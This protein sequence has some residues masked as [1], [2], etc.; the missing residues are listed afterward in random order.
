MPGTSRRAFWATTRS[1]WTT[2][3]TRSR[4]AGRRATCS[5]SAEG[6]PSTP[7][8][9]TVLV[10]SLPAQLPPGPVLLVDPPS[11]SARLLGV[12]LGNGAQILAA[13][14]LLQGLDLG[15]M[16]GETP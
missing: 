12:G 16:A 3:P 6:R 1:D 7:P 8:D 10:G 9:L 5:C 4:R 2:W 15:A 14:P 11:T 13:H